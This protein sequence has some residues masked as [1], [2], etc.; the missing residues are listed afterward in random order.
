[1]IEK[2]QKNEIIINKSKFINYL[3]ILENIDDV[4]KYLNE[5]KNEY[6]D[7]THY[8]YAFI[9]DNVK[10]FND[11]S[12]PSGTAGM[13]LLNVLESNNLNHILTIT[14]R[15]F[16]GIKLGAG[17]LVRAYTKSVTENLKTANIFEYIDGFNFNI[18]I[19][20][21][22]KDIIEP[23]LKKYIKSKKYSDY[24]NYDI[25]VKVENFNEL[26]S[27]FDKNNVEIKNLQKC[28]I[29]SVDN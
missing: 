23:K 18:D 2:N 29:K 6:K 9:F 26:K 16:G 15:Y 17:G 24:I 25:C 7:A 14:V 13:P 20:Y 1:M 11:D 8:C 21:D 4:F 10:R 19:P 5:I 27:L 28:K 22:L 3:I 12:E